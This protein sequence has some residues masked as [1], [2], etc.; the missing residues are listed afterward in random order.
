M[1]AVGWLLRELELVEEGTHWTNLSV[2]DISLKR[3][4]GFLFFNRF[5]KGYAIALRELLLLWFFQKLLQL[6]FTLAIV[7]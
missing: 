3:I 1:V 2:L 7:Q 5:I 6:L 4:L